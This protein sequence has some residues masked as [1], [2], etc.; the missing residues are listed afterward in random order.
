[1]NAMLGTRHVG[2]APSCAAP[3]GIRH[4]HLPSRLVHGGPSALA[5]RRLLDIRV[6]HATASGGA[7]SKLRTLDA[8]LDAWLDASN[9]PRDELGLAAGG[10]AWSGDV[11]SEV[12]VAG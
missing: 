8:F 10:D 9:R 3:A 5:G 4:A 2:G 12:A 6:H 1:M 11:E 7:A